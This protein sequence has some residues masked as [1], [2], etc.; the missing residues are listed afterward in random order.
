MIENPI[1]ENSIRTAK[2]KIRKE[3]LSNRLDTHS[4]LSIFD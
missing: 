4:E 3:A 2:S 1:E